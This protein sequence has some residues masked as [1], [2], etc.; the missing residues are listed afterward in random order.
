MMTTTT[1][2]LTS[3]F[4]IGL[5]GSAHCALMC[6]GISSAI[7]AGAPLGRAL[8][9]A[10][11]SQAGRVLSY[12]IAGTL[13]AWL[14]AQLLTLLAEQQVRIAAKLLLGSAWILIALQMLGVLKNLPWLSQLGA[15]F[16]RLLQ[17][18]SRRVWPIRS[19]WHALAAGAL[20]GWLPCGM[21]YAMLMVA[22]ATADPLLAALLMLAFGIG[23]MPGT[24]LPAMATVRMQKFAVLPRVRQI[25][26]L[27]IL[28]FGVWTLASPWFGAGHH[29]H[30]QMAEPESHLHH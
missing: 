8:P 15:R 24:V 26:A 5:G 27:L 25:M 21:S 16:W 3:A 1:A 10:A 28:A 4:L 19:A 20:W 7:V 6:G 22:A 11:M 14:S 13:V 17:P 18:L 30:M 12:M 23:T 2:T 9:H 29:E